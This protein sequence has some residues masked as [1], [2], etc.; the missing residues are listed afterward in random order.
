MSKLVK[1]VWRAKC[2]FW[3]L[4][5]TSALASSNTVYCAT[6]RTLI[7]GPV[8]CH[9]VTVTKSNNLKHRPSLT[10][11]ICAIETACSGSIQAYF[12]IGVLPFDASCLLFLLFTWISFL[13]LHTIVPV[14][15][16]RNGNDI[17]HINKVT[18]RRARLVL[19]WVTISR[20]YTVSVCN[21]PPRQTA[22]CPQRDGKWVP[23]DALHHDK[24]AAK[25]D[26]QYDK[27]ATELSWQR[28]RRSFSSYSE[29]SKVANFNLPHLHL[30]LRWGDPVWVLPRSSVS[31]N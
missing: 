26:A 5:L 2:E 11:T 19:R 4:P 7:G 31:E 23:R 28:L 24:R 18:P 1:G 20:V 16:W 29:L 13:L 25:V 22:S 14:A 10:R 6:A 3:S 12:C 9:K 27:L 17:G 30:G 21:H 8:L 15:A